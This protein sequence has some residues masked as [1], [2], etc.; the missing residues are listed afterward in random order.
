[1]DS[2]GKTAKA[3][4]GNSQIGCPWFRGQKLGEYR[5]FFIRQRD[6]PPRPILSATHAPGLK[7]CRRKADFGLRRAPFGSEPQGRRQSSRELPS[8][9]TSASSVEPSLSVE[10]SRAVGMAPGAIQTIRKDASPGKPN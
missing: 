8:G 6:P 1:M 5:V 9:L 7:T 10:D 4:T 3:L 2:R